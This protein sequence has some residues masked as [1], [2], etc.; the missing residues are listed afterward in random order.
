M[1]QQNKTKNEKEKDRNF[2]WSAVLLKKFS[3][4]FS[5][6]RQVFNSHVSI[7]SIVPYSSL[8]KKKDP[9]VN[10]FNLNFDSP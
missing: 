5:F 10:N 9:N 8:K 1:L 3:F 6:T 4:F 2:F 7:S